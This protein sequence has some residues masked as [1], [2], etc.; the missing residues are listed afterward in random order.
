MYSFNPVP[1]GLKIEDRGDVVVVTR[2][3]YSH[4]DWIL[5]LFSVVWNVFLF[6][7]YITKLGRPSPNSMSLWFSVIDVGVGIF[8]AYSA[9]AGFINRTEFS[10]GNDK[11]VVRHKPLLWPGNKAIDVSKIQQLFCDEVL[12]TNRSGAMSSY[13]LNAVMEDGQK[14]VVLSAG[15]KRDQAL[16]LEHLAENQLG[17]KAALVVGELT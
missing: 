12:S 4:S 10:I 11:L 7:W 8:T 1:E 16:Y 2:N 14:E 6:D 13:R 3:W 17:I 5:T 15:I 9:L